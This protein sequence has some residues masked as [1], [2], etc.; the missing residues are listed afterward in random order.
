MTRRWPPPAGGRLVN[1]RGRRGHIIPAAK[2]LH[3]FES[4]LVTVDLARDLIFVADYTTAA[5]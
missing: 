4:E 2:S 3:S 1:P 5:A